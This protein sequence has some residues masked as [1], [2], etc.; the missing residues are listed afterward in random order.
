MWYK[1]LTLLPKRS[2]TTVPQ[3]ALYAMNSDFVANAATA[4]AERL[5]DGTDKDKIT[6]LYSLVFGR[7]PSEEELTLGVAFVDQMPWEQYTQVILMTN[8]LMFID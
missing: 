3:Q 1:R 6:E 4:L 5:G 8:E 7:L 2:E